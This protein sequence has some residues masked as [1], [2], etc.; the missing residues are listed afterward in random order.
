MSWSTGK[1]SAYALY[2]L[3]KSHDF[4]IAGLFT[5]VNEAYQRVAMHS[6]RESLLRYQA[7]ALELPLEIVLIPAN[8]SN[9]IYEAK[10]RNLIEKAMTSEV[11]AMAFGDL[12]LEDVRAYREKLLVGT[13]IEPI[14]PLWGRPTGELAR[15]IIDSGIAA[16][17]T[18]V[19]LNKLSRA[20]AGKFFDTRTIKSFSSDIDPC[21]ERGEFHTFVFEG[22]NF[23]KP[24][25]VV[26]GET[27]ER[28][29]FAFAD[30]LPA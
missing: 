22:P 3:G 8:C 10:M 4:K 11:A 14:F 12:F 5:T 26:I 20:Y 18:C 25:P 13:G 19:D 2:E 16:V 29:G 17:L 23:S 7:E 24:I 15:E 21:G 1:D 28:D 6:T 30:V 9:E 27:V